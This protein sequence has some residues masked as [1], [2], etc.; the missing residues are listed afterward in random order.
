MV[1]SLRDI[2]CQVQQGTNAIAAAVAQISAATTEQAASSAQQSAAITQTA[3]A[4]EQVKVIA[5][6]TAD[7]ATLV[8]QG[9]Q[10]AL[11]VARHSDQTVGE[12]VGSMGQ[13][14]AQVA[15]IAQTIHSL[16]AQT[17]S[18]SAIITTVSELADQI[19]HLALNAAIET[20]RSH[21]Q[22]RDVATLARLV[23]D[24]GSQAK[25]ATQQVRAILSEIQSSTKAAVEVSDEGT[26]RV[27]SGVQLVSATGAMI[28]QI[29]AEVERG[30][31]ANVQMA[32]AA[33]Q[34][35]LGMEQIAQ[36]MTSIQQAMTQ[37]LIGTRQTEEVAQGL[38]DLAQSLQRSI[39]VY[40]L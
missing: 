8:A 39:A 17:R 9:S 38:L 14:R 7:Q 36:A 34:Q 5:L 26:R 19:N 29:A 30:A 23:R 6:Q 37:T 10:A 18:I 24:L 20:T 4:I 13:I 28:H 16:S 2:T 1:T 33:Q 25:Q 21:E 31:Q 22:D 32:A 15:S 3:T 35:T 11:D 12:T 27:E 40:R